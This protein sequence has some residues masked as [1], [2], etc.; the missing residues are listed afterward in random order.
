MNRGRSYINGDA[1]RPV[2]KMENQRNE[3]ARSTDLHRLSHDLRTPLTSIMGFAELLL[4]D[5]SIQGQARDYLSIIAEESKK[6]ADILADHL[7]E[8]DSATNE[9]SREN[10]LCDDEEAG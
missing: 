6:L 8:F 10:S 7:A 5:D 2:S 9:S 4:E 1:G 3:P